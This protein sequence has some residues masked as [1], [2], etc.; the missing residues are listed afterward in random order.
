MSQTSDF[1]S[2]PVRE[3][4]SH[5]LK[6]KSWLY[7]IVGAF[8]FF[9]AL[10]SFVLP[11]ALFFPIGIV[12]ISIES[13][14]CASLI[15]GMLIALGISGIILERTYSKLRF[16][17]KVIIAVGKQFARDPDFYTKIEHMHETTPCLE[18]RYFMQGILGDKWWVKNEKKVD[19]DYTV[20][21]NKSVLDEILHVVHETKSEL[22]ETKNK[23]ESVTNDLADL[24]SKKSEKDQIISKKANVSNN[25]ENTKT[26]DDSNKIEFLDE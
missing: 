5:T 2:R 14:I 12:F 16:Y 21:I 9:F 22:E 13:I 6:D 25:T 19:R 17:E 3:I 7:Y 8:V 26:L 4:L 1:K 24:K 11:N 18:I 15:V 10:F 20:T 23:L